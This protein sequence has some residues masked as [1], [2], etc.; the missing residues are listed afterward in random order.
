MSCP[1]CGV[2]M[3]DD[4]RGVQCLNCNVESHRRKVVLDFGTPIQ[5]FGKTLGPRFEFDET[6]SAKEFCSNLGVDFEKVCVQ[7]KGEA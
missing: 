3:P 4:S 1:S 2:A 7:R 6:H 5:L